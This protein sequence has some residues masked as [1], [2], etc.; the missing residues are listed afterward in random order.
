MRLRTEKLRLFLNRPRFFHDQREDF[1][2]SFFGDVVFFCEFLVEFFESFFTRGV[3]DWEAV[4]LFQGSYGAG[5][6]HA[7]RDGADDGFIEF[8]DL[9]AEV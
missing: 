1:L 3:F 4:E 8:V 2:E 9:G 6:G 7:L 5:N